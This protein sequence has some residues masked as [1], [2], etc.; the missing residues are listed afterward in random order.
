MRAWVL[1]DIGDFRY[2]EVSEPELSDWDV[3]V[4]VKATGICGSDIPRIYKTGAHK[5]PLIPGHEFSGEVVK[6]GRRV[7]EVWLGKRV[8]IFPLIPCRECAPCRTKQYEMCRQYNYLGSRCDGSFAEYVAVPV[9]NLVELP[10]NVSFEDAAM[11]EPMAVAV[12]AM[13]RVALYSTDT[14]VVCG[15]GTI[16]LFLTMFLMEKGIENLFVIGNKTAQKEKILLLDLP[17]DCYCDSSTQDVE[18][19]IMLRTKG[20]GANVFFECVGKNVTVSQAVELTAPAGRICVVGNPYSDMLLKKDTYWKILRHQLTVIG[21]WNSSYIGETT[22]D[23]HYVLSKLEGKRISPAA[24]ISHRFL[25]KDLEQGF[26][27]MR[28]KTEDYIKIMVLTEDT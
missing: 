2:E 17:E 13:R 16:G 7:E 18:D 8:G 20:Q 1:H 9:W 27:I 12:H 19:W 25:M 15:L 4:S 3:L 11:L 23:W 10:E 21:T 6:L 24:L 28:D 14:V 5:M 22:D 26:R